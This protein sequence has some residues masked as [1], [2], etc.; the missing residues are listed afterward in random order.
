MEPDWG[1]FEELGLRAF[2]SSGVTDSGACRC[3][4]GSQCSSPGKHPKYRGWWDSAGTPEAYARWRSGDNLA[5]A[6]GRGVAVL[7]WDGPPPTERP[8]P[9]TL[10]TRT[11][12]GGEHWFVKTSR[13]V[14]NGVKVFDGILDIR[15]EGGFV[16][17]PPSMHRN[18]RRYEWMAQEPLGLPPLWVMGYLKSPR[19]AKVDLPAWPTEDIAEESVFWEDLFDQLIDDLQSATAG[20]RNTALFRSACRVADMICSGGLFMRRMTELAD[21]AVS[22]GLSPSEVQRTVRSALRTVAVVDPSR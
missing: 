7:D 11:P 19:P 5:V 14:R 16:V 4:S 18:L 12:S 8:R 9:K 10:M 3:S 13:Q 1:M 21:A 22:T 6:T 20:T 17:V 2:P 15:G